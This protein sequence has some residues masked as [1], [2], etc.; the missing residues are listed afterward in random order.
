MK[1]EC[2]DMLFRKKLYRELEDLQTDVNAWLQTYN[3]TR[4]HS[5]KHCFGKTPMQT[6]IEGKGIAQ[7][8]NNDTVHKISDTTTQQNVDA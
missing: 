1:E 7:S 8:K 4:P 5:G 2:Y 6:F 3:E